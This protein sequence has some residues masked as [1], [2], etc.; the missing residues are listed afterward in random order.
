MTGN[1]EHLR[2]RGDYVM[3]EKFLMML[4]LLEKKFILF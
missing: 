1:I 4:L 3:A 2:F